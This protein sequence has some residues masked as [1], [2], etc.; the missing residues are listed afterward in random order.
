M[1]TVAWP[2]RWALAANSTL[3]GSSMPDRLG[4]SHH[5]S[6]ELA[7]GEQAGVLISHVRIWSPGLREATPERGRVEQGTRGS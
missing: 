7:V 4:F 3:I 1:V 6:R 2:H 5:M